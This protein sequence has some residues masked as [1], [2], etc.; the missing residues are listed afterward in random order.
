M[1]SVK[2]RLPFGLLLLCAS[3]YE[4]NGRPVL[5]LL[6]FGTALGAGLAGFGA[7]LTGSIGGLPQLSS[8]N[9]YES[10][11]PYNS[12]NPYSLYNPYFNAFTP[13]PYTAFPQPVQLPSLPGI[14]GLP[15]ALPNLPNAN[16]YPS[17]PGG[18]SPNSGVVGNLYPILYP[19]YRPPT[20]GFAGAFDRLS[21]TVSKFGNSEGLAFNYLLSGLFSSVGSLFN[22]LFETNSLNG[23]IYQ[24]G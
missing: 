22:G 18:F 9:P 1:Y 11:N 3:I 17:L 5:G 14:S 10:Y 4:A 8:Y 21:D 15:S 23:N 6:T 20:S 7:G 2:I 12:Y 24:P 13:Y 16:T 19:P